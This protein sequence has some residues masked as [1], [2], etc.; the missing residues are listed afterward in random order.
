MRTERKRLTIIVGIIVLLLLCAIV[1]AFALLIHDTNIDFNTEFGEI[2]ADATDFSAQSHQTFI[3]T[4]AGENH[5][6]HFTVSNKAD[7]PMR[8]SIE[9]SLPQESSGLENAIFVYCDNQLL[10]TL[11]SARNSVIAALSEDNLLGAKVGENIDSAS[12]TLT[13]QLHNGADG[14]IYQN[15]EFKAIVILRASTIDYQSNIMVSTAEEFAQAVTD[16]NYSNKKRT[17]RLLS[18]IALAEDIVLTKACDIDL[19]G[20][21]LVFEGKTLK[22]NF[23]TVGTARI[24]SSRANSTTSE[25]R[26][27]IMDSDK[28]ALVFGKGALD[29]QSTVS[30]LSCDMQAA[31]VLM[32]SNVKSAIGVGI[33]QGASLAIA[34]GLE[35]YISD[36]KLKITK[37]YGNF[38]LSGTVI[39]TNAFTRTQ[40]GAVLVGAQLVEFKLLGQ[41][42]EGYVAIIDEKFAY[43]D[44]LT[45]G[46]SDEDLDF[47]LYLPS[48]FEDINAIVTYQSLNPSI[49][50]DSGKCGDSVEGLVTLIATVHINGVTLTKNMTFSV[51]KQSNQMRFDY[52]VA[53]I[54]EQNLSALYDISMP[55]GSYFVLPIVEQGNTEDYRAMYSMRSLG[56][57]S[58]TY[59][60]SPSFHYLSMLDASNRIH[61]VEPTLETYAEVLIKGKFSNERDKEYTS[62]IGIQIKTLDNTQLHKQILNY[63]QTLLNEVDILQN[64]LD[65]R[66]QLGMANERGDFTLPSEYKGFD[67][68]Y[69]S[70]SPLFSKIEYIQPTADADG[71]CLFRLDLSKLS[72]KPSAAIIQAGIRIKG[73]SSE[74]LKTE[75]PMKVN[76]PS[77][78][79]I[80][81]GGIA[82]TEL[83]NSIKIQTVQ[84]LLNKDGTLQQGVPT[85]TASTEGDGQLLNGYILLHD[86]LQVKKLIIRTGDYPYGNTLQK[87]EYD[88]TANLY[89]YSVNNLAKIHLGLGMFNN[90]DYLAVN[91]NAQL[92]NGTSAAMSQ[93][94]GAL[95]DMIV[96]EYKGLTHLELT[97][98]HLT[99]AT[100]I[101][102]LSALTHLDLQGNDLLYNMEFL[103]ARTNNTLNYLDISG[104]GYDFATCH[105]VLSA[106]HYRHTILGGNTASQWYYTSVNGQRTQYVNTD[107]TSQ[108]EAYFYIYTLAIGKDTVTSEAMQLKWGIVTSTLGQLNIKWSLNDAINHAGLSIGII[109]TDTA[110]SKVKLSNNILGTTKPTGGGVYEHC[111]LRAEV[112]FTDLQT[113]ELRTVSRIFKLKLAY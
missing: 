99:S 86:V 33:A 8:Y 84:Q 104:T 1:P 59:E 47:D 61:L 64:V 25:S 85:I 76:T 4:R 14:S 12:H 9:I 103:C 56:L 3:F 32:A 67:L 74:S 19:M 50:S 20:R 92:F 5:D 62:S 21:A 70:T 97:K 96:S 60:L 111:P 17:I 49:L 93:L 37:Q 65:T 26:G 31:E 42:A 63:I 7:K 28:S 44:M 6:L 18:D 88:A 101:L 10:G 38:V 51:L 83:F 16:V 87:H 52:L 106:L 78:I 81:D 58:L 40:I 34:D 107:T 89:Y 91:N 95:L 110:S 24:F 45:M 27:I 69:T 77:A 29:Y 11:A 71:K 109:V 23:A 75:S 98:A 66:A 73:G 35:H 57:D 100:Q 30:I 48:K 72:Q 108:L 68:T 46:V 41:D 90:V 102:K 43:L 15:K 13:F 112:T 105:G 2:P 94:T 53:R 36:A 54:G 82:D 79:V 22:L 80:A 55:K 39:T 113:G